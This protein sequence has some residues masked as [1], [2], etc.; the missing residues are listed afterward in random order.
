MNLHFNLPIP[1][2]VSTTDSKINGVP[3]RHYT[4]SNSPKAVV[5]YMH[6]GGFMVGDLESHHTICADICDQTGLDV[7]SVDYRLSPE[8]PHPA[9]YNDTLAVF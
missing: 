1:K 8:H 3:T 6:G 5:Q 9:A 4:C 2:N 7:V